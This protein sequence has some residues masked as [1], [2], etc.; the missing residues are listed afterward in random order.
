MFAAFHADAYFSLGGEVLLHFIVWVEVV[1]IQ[2][3]FEFKLVWNLEKIWKNK[4]LFHFFYLLW[5]ETSSPAQ[6]GTCSHPG[7]QPNWGPP[8]PSHPTGSRPSR[9]SSSNAAAAPVAGPPCHPHRLDPVGDSRPYCTHADNPDAVETE[10]DSTLD[11]KNRNWS[12]VKKSPLKNPK[13]LH[14]FRAQSQDRIG[15]ESK[16][17]TPDHSPY[18]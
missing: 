16:L 15:L 12:H 2:I 1:E 10:P 7:A 13:E 9:G 14:R 18:K 8:W 3:W 5:A 17:P 11:S 4:S 6:P